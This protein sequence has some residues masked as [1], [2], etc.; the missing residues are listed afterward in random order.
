[1]LQIAPKLNLK[2]T[3]CGSENEAAALKAAG[4]R[5]VRVVS[6]PED[7]YKYSH[8][9]GE[10]QLDDTLSNFGEFVFAFS[11]GNEQ[12]RDDLAVR[13]GDTKCRWV[14][15]PKG[16][17]S[18]ADFLDCEPADL[19]NLVQTARPMW[20][21]EICTIDDIPE[22]GIERLYETGFPRLDQHGFRFVRPA[23][24][25]VIGPYG[26]LPGS[27]QFYTRDGWKRLDEWSDGDVGLVYDFE[28]G[29]TKYEHVGRVAFDAPDGFLSIKNA[30]TA[31]IVACEKHRWPV[32]GKG[33][34]KKVLTTSEIA[35]A[36][37]SDHGSGYSL[38]RTFNAPDNPDLPLSDDQI[39]LRVAICADG[40]IRQRNSTN[41]ICVCVRKERK[42]HRLVEL[43]EATNTE[44]RVR[45]YSHRPT[46]THY[47]FDGHENKSLTQFR[48]ASPRQ[49]RVV[50]DELQHWDG[51]VYDESRLVLSTSI[52]EDAE[53]CEYL[54]SA[55]G[56]RASVFVQNSNPETQQ[57]NYLVCANTKGALTRVNWSSVD[58]VRSVDGKKYCLTT[59]TGF[60][61]CRLAPG[62]IFVTGNS[63]KSVLLRQLSVNVW[64]MH[65]WRTLITSFEEKV[66]PRFQRD[67]RRHL[68]GRASPWTAEEIAKADAEIRQAFRFLRRK[69]NT[70]LDLERL[71]N[72]I[73]Y[74]VKVYGVEV[75]IID[76]VNEIDHQVPKGESRT[77][78][79]G[80][81][82][83]RLKQLADDY[84]LL[85]IVAAHPPKDGVEKRL[86]KNGLLTLN[87]G[88]D[89]AHYGNK[90]DIGWCVWR[91]IDG[92]TLLHVDKVKDHET[93]GKPTLVELVLDS[94]MNAF[95]EN[96]IGYEIL[97]DQAG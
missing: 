69:R 53:F 74:A 77:D 89:T 11:E 22:P 42:K 51:H 50:F 59:T 5:S 70:T 21:D 79:M 41:R 4:I 6:K 94:R 55:C 78:Y 66:K 17:T 20:T 47:D 81:F 52:K 92:P 45:N 16:V 56:H 48:D 75:V 86:A 44:Y 60:F 93:M 8:D 58:R 65:G 64:R 35:D 19:A 72:R 80:K 71:M 62:Q 30:G 31:E 3:F 46:E 82:I 49:L 27:A 23:F 13:L 91:N 68:I 95:R 1:M 54:F 18:A 29:D 36:G 43:L 87:D 25:P 9:A 97:G 2:L 57:D 76:P 26:P 96:R 83:M 28:S 40:S 67:L 85:M 14:R 73:E 38:I 24:M 34:A 32:I 63:G 90:A 12:L 39:R 10:W 15:W 37:I 61:V 88:A 7:V 84:S 33:G